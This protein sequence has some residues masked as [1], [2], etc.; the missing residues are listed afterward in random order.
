[1]N[2]LDL[3]GRLTKDPDLRFTTS[4]IAVCRFTLAVDRGLSKDKKMEA[5]N[6][7]QPTADFIGVT[8]FGK[9]AELVSSY[10]TKGQQLAVTGRIQTSSYKGQDGKMAYRTDVIADRVYFISNSNGNNKN[11]NG[12]K[13]EE[14][15][16]YDDFGLGG[17]AFPLPD[18]DIPF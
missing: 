8:A 14:T 2:N 13:K 11:N 5:E 12:A 15:P 18:D 17:D 4:G 1:M 16:N 10:I 7:G 6:K 3:I 9:T